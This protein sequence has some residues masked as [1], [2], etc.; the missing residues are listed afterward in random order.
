VTAK[1]NYAKTVASVIRMLAKFGSDA[2]M[3]SQTGAKYN[4]ATSTVEATFSE[5]P[6]T[7][8]LVDYTSQ[9]IDGT[10]IQASDRRLL[11]APDVEQAP[12]TGD[13]FRLAGGAELTVI[14]VTTTAPAGTVVLYDIQARG[15]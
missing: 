10:L 11:V 9:D 7:A 4:P 15:Q 2:R 6:C 1:F 3:I 12:Q 14:R 5:Y 8:A 13:V